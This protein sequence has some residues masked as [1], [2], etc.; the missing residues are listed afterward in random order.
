MTASIDVPAAHAFVEAAWKK[1][2]QSTVSSC[3]AA[4][5]RRAAWLSAL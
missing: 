4:W 1:D 5:R 2:I 3:A